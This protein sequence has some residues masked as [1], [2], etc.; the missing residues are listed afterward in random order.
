MEKQKIKFIKLFRLTEALGLSR[1]SV[2]SGIVKHLKSVS[3]KLLLGKPLN[4][5]ITVQG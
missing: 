2:E 4:Y 5:E 1:T 3:T